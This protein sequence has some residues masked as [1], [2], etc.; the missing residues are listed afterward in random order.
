[1]GRFFLVCLGGAIGTGARY[2]IAT[3]VP[4]LLGS[5]FPYATLVVN[6]TGSF[7]LGAIMHAGL[8]TTVLS[9]TLR[10]VLSTGVMGG[11]T[12]Y[13][14]FNYET[15]ELLREGALS[16]AGLNVATTVSLCLLGGVL[17]ATLARSLLGS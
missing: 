15:L 10:V 9:P 16:L 1:M 14:T 11:F 8:T 2:L 12:T 17:G 6:V 13:S 7:C 3:T 5:S 4:R